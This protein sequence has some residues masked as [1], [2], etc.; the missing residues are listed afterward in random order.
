M[1]KTKAGP[2]KSKGPAGPRDADGAPKAADEPLALD[3]E[4]LLGHVMAKVRGDWQVRSCV[5]RNESLCLEL[6]VTLPALKHSV[7]KL[8]SRGLL[9]TY[10]RLSWEPDDLCVLAL[11]RAG[12]EHSTSVFRGELLRHQGPDHRR[13]VGL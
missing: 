3:D 1:T 11:T 8:M 9:K 12:L 10:A 6:R 13:R 5:E 7:L 2:R 4:R